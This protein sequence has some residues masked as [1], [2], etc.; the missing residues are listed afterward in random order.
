MQQWCIDTWR[1]TRTGREASVEALPTADSREEWEARLQRNDTA[2]IELVALET[3]HVGLRV[4]REKGDSKMGILS[5]SDWEAEVF[6]E[7]GG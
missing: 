2:E 5:P 1:R 4:H 3:E 7:W 6:S